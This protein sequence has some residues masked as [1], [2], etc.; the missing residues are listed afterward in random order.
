MAYNF[1]DLEQK[2]DDTKEWLKTEYFS[3]RTGR[4]TPAVLDGVKVESYGAMVALNQVA[5]I[6]I[7]DARTLR[8]LPY[9]PAQG[10][11]I[12]KGISSTNL[13][14]S[15]SA[16]DR[17]VRVFFPELTAENRQ[18]LTKVVKDKLEQARISLRSERDDVWGDIQKKEKDGE[19][20]E[21]EKFGYKEDMQKIID[22][23]NNELESIADTK[24]A[25]LSS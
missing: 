10:K 24:E 16:D 4:A 23:A 11:E 6:T 2:A 12:E 7:E 5:N 9:D 15:V 18:T 25:E 21:D 17:G 19:M 22:A 14:L 1:S 3:I 8:I 20:S 13:G